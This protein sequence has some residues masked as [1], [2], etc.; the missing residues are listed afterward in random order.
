MEIMDDRS[1]RAIRFVEWTARFWSLAS[2][3]LVLAFVFGE[4]VHPAS[5]IE[6]VGFL[7][8][9]LGITIGMAIGWWREGLGGA[10]TVACLGAFYV[11]HLVTSGRFPSGWAWL[12]FAAPGFLFLLGWAGERRHSHGPRA[13]A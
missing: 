1:G 2:V 4:G 9:P 5:T 3:G 11:L 13:H 10:I 7:F 12:V 6:W 8:F